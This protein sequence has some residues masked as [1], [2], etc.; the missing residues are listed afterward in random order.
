M[1]LRLKKAEGPMTEPIPAHLSPFIVEQPYG[2]YTAIDHAVWRYVMRQNVAFHRDHA[3]AIY[4]EG[5]KGSGIGIEEIPRIETMNEALSRFGWRAV[6]VDGFIPPAAF[7]EFQARGILPIACDMRSVEHV[8]YTPAP[9]IIHESAGHA[10]I[11]CDPSFTAFVKTICELGAQALSTPEDDALYEAIRLLSIV[12]ETPSS[13]PEE[14]QAAEERLKECQ[15]A[16]GS[17]SEAN[18]VSRLYWWTVE[19]GLIGDLDNPR[20]Y[21]AGLLS[22]VGESQRVFT[23]AVA[24][25]PFDLDTCITT[26]YDITSYQPQ[27]F[28]CESFEQLTEAVHVLADRLGIPL[29]RLESATESVPIP[30]R[31]SSR[32]AQD[33]PEKAYPAELIAAYQALRDLRT[34]GVS[35]T[36]REAR[37][38]SLYEELGRYPEDW[39]I[40]LEWLELATQ[41]QVMPEAQAEVREALSRLS[42]TPDRRELIA[43]GLA[44]I[45]TAP[46]ASVS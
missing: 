45:G 33:T 25:V 39:L 35:S 15:A 34:G 12:K 18:M 20:I 8:A 32:S 19:Y 29:G 40:R 30:P 10:P 14:I 26:S 13:T 46:A 38:A 6:A 1:S 36:E 11:L 17:V 28:V 42:T 43:N 5:L 7:M 21:G 4:L 24:K 3:H 2:S 31:V 23:D 44:L 37:L 16:I 9:D 27:L 22:S 41:H